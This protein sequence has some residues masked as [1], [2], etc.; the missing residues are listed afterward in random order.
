[1]KVASNVFLFTDMSEE[2]K[3]ALMA[4]ND[5]ATSSSAY[6][7]TRSSA[8][9][10]ERFNYRFSDPL[11]DPYRHEAEQR[12]QEYQALARKSNDNEHNLKV[13]CL[14]FCFLIKSEGRLCF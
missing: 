12:S 3:R 11:Q 1:M 7:G 9:C 14:I 10:L 13:V 4:D 6:S 5:N 2:S 8:L